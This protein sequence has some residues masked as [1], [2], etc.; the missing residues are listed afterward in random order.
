MNEPA[1]SDKNLI[2]GKPRYA[3]PGVIAATAATNLQ[4]EFF[5]ILAK[6]LMLDD[7]LCGEC[8]PVEFLKKEIQNSNAELM[9]NYHLRKANEYTQ[10]TRK[11]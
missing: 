7:L 3:T 10:D 8:N 2:S 4:D 5:E 11:E 9:R 6:N 1:M